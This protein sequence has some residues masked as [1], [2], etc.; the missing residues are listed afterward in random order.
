MSALRNV[1]E[2]S[3]WAS[4]ADHHAE[5]SEADVDA[6]RVHPASSWHRDLVRSAHLAATLLG[7]GVP[8]SRVW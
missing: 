8:S 3:S 7:L 4:D 6:S 5:S 1:I 2:I